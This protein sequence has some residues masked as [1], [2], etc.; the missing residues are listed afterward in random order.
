MQPIR[1]LLSYMNMTYI[2]VFLD[3]IEEQKKTLPKSVL[4]QLSK[5]KIDRN[6]LPALIHGEIF[7][8]GQ[9]VIASYLLFRFDRK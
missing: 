1:N 3:R 7:I 9:N 4:Q 5:H 6:Q 8:E 2:E